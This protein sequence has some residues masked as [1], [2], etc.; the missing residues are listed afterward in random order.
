[1][2]ESAITEW[3]IS[4]TGA[5]AAAIPPT[6]GTLIGSPFLERFRFDASDAGHFYD[7]HFIV[8]YTGRKKHKPVARILSTDSECDQF[9]TIQQPPGQTIVAL[10]RNG[11]NRNSGP[12]YEASSPNKA[13]TYSITGLAEHNSGGAGRDNGVLLTSLVYFNGLHLKLE[14]DDYGGGNSPD[15][16][17]NDKIV[18]VFFPLVYGTDFSQVILTPAP[19]SGM[20]TKI[21]LA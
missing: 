15:F 19:Y 4:P 1:M 6:Y 8:I 12:W 18:E 10:N 17:F 2:N 21:T 7:G 20:P 16:D 14:C 11:R 13:T 5:Q 3:V 9:L